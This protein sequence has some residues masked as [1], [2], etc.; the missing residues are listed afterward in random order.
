MT[1]ATD[2]V[3]IGLITFAVVVINFVVAVIIGR[4]LG[5]ISD[6]LTSRNALIVPDELGP[7]DRIVIWHK[8]DDA[9]PSPGGVHPAEPPP[10]DDPPKPRKPIVGLE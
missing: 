6:T 1:L 2:W 4:R 3:D 10:G 9:D 8:D 5:A 7:D